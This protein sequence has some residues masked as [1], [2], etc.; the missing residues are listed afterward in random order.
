M[1]IANVHHFPSLPSPSTNFATHVTRPENQC[2]QKQAHSF[3]LSRGPIRGHYS[4]EELEFS[5]FLPGFGQS[6]SGSR[7]LDLVR[8]R[9]C[10]LKPNHLNLFCVFHSTFTTGGGS[11]GSGA[12]P[13]YAL[14][15]LLIP[16]PSPSFSFTSPS[17]AP[18]HLPSLALKFSLRCRSLD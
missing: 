10:G 3:R 12:Y 6:F 14:H 13:T 16:L 1:R 17:A 5:P 2:V 8:N 18:L 15:T 9:L 7:L 11:E 4:P